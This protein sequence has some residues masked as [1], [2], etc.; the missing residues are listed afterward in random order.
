M[1]DCPKCRGEMAEVK[2][3]YV[4][5]NRCEDYLGIWF[6]FA[7]L[8]EMTDLVAAELIDAGPPP[9]VTGMDEVRAVPCPRCARRMVTV[10]DR[11]QPHIAYEVCPA[12]F[13]CFLDAGEF[14]DLK[15]FS[16]TERLRHSLRNL[17]H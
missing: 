10:N 3:H 12:C 16:F 14:A 6:D 17:T 2:H 11:E 13:G 9:V 8:E 5:V 7:E 4:V 15:D 1:M